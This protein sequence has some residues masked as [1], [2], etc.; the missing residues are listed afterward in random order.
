[1]SLADNASYADLAA[2]I[3]GLSETFTTEGNAVIIAITASFDETVLVGAEVGVTDVEETD[4]EIDEELTDWD[5]AAD[6]DAP[7][8]GVAVGALVGVGAAV[9][10]AV[11]AGTTVTFPWL[12]ALVI[13]A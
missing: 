3:A 10:V 9:G 8:V 13:A 6:V 5:D 2:S 7:G 1:M 12:I 4:E 11:G